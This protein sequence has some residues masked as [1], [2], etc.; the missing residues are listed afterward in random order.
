MALSFSKVPSEDLY[1]MCLAGEES[2]WKYV[3]NYVLSIARWPRW[4]LRESP[5]DLAQRI[6]LFLLETG[7]AQAREPKAFRGFVRR[8]AVNKILDHL[9]SPRPVC[10]PIG[11]PDGQDTGP[12]CP[13]DPP[14]DGPALEDHV[15]MV[16]LTGAISRALLGLPKYCRRVVPQ[17]FRYRLGLYESYTELARSLGSSVGTV[18]G[19]VRRCLNLL[20]QSRELA[21]WQ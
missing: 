2:A 17:Y 9:K 7:L 8:V 13:V 18:S 5:E 16:D 11:Q 3:Y 20:A 4:S 19:Q 21:D 10:V 1:G 14:S 6:V 15:S 12:G